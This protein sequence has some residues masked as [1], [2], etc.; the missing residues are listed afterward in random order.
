MKTLVKEHD[1]NTMDK[2]HDVKT[3]DKEHDV[4]TMDKVYQ[5]KEG[6]L[7]TNLYGYFSRLDIDQAQV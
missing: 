4:K 7:L 1:V 6:L 3:M 5:E 2:E